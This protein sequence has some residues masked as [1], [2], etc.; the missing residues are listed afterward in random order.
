MNWLELF[1]G[2]PLSRRTSALLLKICS[3]I[4]LQLSAGIETRWTL[5]FEI[6]NQYCIIGELVQTFDLD[7]TTSVLLAQSQNEVV[8]GFLGKL[9]V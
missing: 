1:S 5:T 9:K 3:H 7:Q 2:R 8:D 6:L 4:L